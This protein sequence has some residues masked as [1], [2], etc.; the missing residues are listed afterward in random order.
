MSDRLFRDRRDAGRALAGLLDRYRGRSGLVVL[1]LPPGGAPV[2]Y[3]V[4]RALGAPL[5][6]FVVRKLGVPGQEELAMGAIAGEDA[7]ALNDDVVRGL[8]HPSGGDRARRGAGGARDRSPGA[9]YRQDLPPQRVDGQDGDPRRRRPRD[10]GEHAGR[11]Q[12]AA[13]PAAR[14]G[15]W[16]PCPPPPSDLPRN[17]AR[18]PTRWSARPHRRRSS[19]SD[20][21]YWDFTQI[22]RRGRARRSCG[23]PRRRCP[24]GPE[25]GARPRPVPSG[26]RRCRCWTG[27]P[28]TEALFDLVGDAHLVLIGEA[29]HGTHEFYAARAAMTRRLIEEKG[30]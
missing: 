11:D 15:S 26:R 2:A 18:W 24:R 17:C 23:R 28:P 6:V 22:D 7:L 9:A 29:S 25:A 20:P 3:E 16:W 21:S 1:A 19:R 8:C 13:P 5:D 10:R 27:A 30:F 12:G 14:P 4:A